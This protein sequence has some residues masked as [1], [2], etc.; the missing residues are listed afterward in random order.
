MPASTTAEEFF[1]RS[2]PAARPETVLDSA[3]N[4]HVLLIGALAMAEST[5]LRTVSVGLL[6]IVEKTQWDERQ[7]ALEAAAPA[8]ADDDELIIGVPSQLEDG[9]DREPEKPHMSAERWATAY[10]LWE[11]SEEHVDQ[12]IMAYGAMLLLRQPDGSRLFHVHGEKQADDHL[13]RLLHETDK[14]L[15]TNIYRQ[16]VQRPM[17]APRNIEDEAGNSPAGH[18]ST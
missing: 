13:R 5:E 8:A 3:G 6:Y 1:S 11:K 7:P 15:L 9:G 18:A 14:V 10:W 2:L 16:F 4:E 12:A 17:D